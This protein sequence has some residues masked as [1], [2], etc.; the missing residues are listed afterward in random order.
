MKNIVLLGGGGH[1]RAIISILPEEQK[2]KLLGYVDIAD[3]G[4]LSGA[5]Y[6][7]TDEF[8][9]GRN[10]ALKLVAAFSYTGLK[11]DIQPRSDIIKKFSELGFEFETV[12]S[13]RSIIENSARIGDGTVIFPGAIINRGTKIGR[14][15]SINSGSIIEHDCILHNNVQISPGAIVCGGAEIFDNSFIGAGSVIRD[16]IIIGTNVIIGMGTKVVKSVIDPGT[17]MEGTFLK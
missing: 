6:L 3:R 4:A 12:I 7:G 1:A 10:H 2:S 13:E 5:P 11:V 9:N 15:C 17:Y 16:G 8:L 14:N